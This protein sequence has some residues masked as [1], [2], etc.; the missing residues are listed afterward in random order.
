MK[1][2]NYGQIENRDTEEPKT[3]PKIIEQWC[4]AWNGGMSHRKASTGSTEVQGAALNQGLRVTCSLSQSLSFS[5]LPRPIQT[6]LTLRSHRQIIRDKGHLSNLQIVKHVGKRKGVLL[7]LLSKAKKHYVAELNNI[8]FYRIFLSKWY[9]HA[10]LSQFHFSQCSNYLYTFS[11]FSHTG[12]GIIGEFV[13]NS[14]QSMWEGHDS[15]HISH[16]SNHIGLQLYTNIFS[17]QDGPEQ[18]LLMTV[19]HFPRWK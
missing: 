13:K 19:S 1:S 16:R 15:Q 9:W 7:L 14:Y 8:Y 3:H 10:Y 11:C 2:K 5:C 12:G 6:K 4:I 17:S 18:S